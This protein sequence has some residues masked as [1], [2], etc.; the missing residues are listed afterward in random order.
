MSEATV[1][2]GLLERWKR[3]AKMRTRSDSTK[4]HMQH[5]EDIVC[6]KGFNSYYHALQ[7]ARKADK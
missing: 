1:M 4:T 5:L 3:E 2:L 6:E 7:V